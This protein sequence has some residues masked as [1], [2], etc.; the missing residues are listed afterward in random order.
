MVFK[1]FSWR[2]LRGLRLAPAA[3]RLSAAER[4]DAGGSSKEAAAPGQRRL[5]QHP[6]RGRSAAAVDEDRWHIEFN[7]R[8]LRSHITLIT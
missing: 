8:L 4:G 6:H 2:A 5:V 7:L 1:G 3:E